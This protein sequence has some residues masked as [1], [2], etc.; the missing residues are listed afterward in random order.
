MVSFTY[1]H[2]M[3]HYICGSLS[4]P[5]QMGTEPVA[6]IDNP[7]NTHHYGFNS[8]SAI[9]PIVALRRPSLHRG[10]TSQGFFKVL[11]P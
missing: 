5:M 4:R 3:G 7:P 8:P 1:T 6:D 9:G 2:Y 10:T 11:H